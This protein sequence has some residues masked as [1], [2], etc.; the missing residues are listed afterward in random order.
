M[1][2]NV[3]DICKEEDISDNVNNRNNICGQQT[4]VKHSADVSICD[5]SDRIGSI[6]LLGLRQIQNA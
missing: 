5:C 3:F 2:P 6:D 1:S 4:K